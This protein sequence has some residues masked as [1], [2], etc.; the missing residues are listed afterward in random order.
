M[1]WEYEER[2]ARVGKLVEAI[3][4][5][6]GDP[7]GKSARTRTRTSASGLSPHGMCCLSTVRGLKEGASVITSKAANDN[8]LKTGQRR[9]RPGQ[10]S[11]TLSVAIKQA[12]FCS[13]SGTSQIDES[14][15]GLSVSVE[16]VLCFPTSCGNHQEEVAEG[17]HIDFHS[18]GT[19]HRRFLRFSFGFPAAQAVAFWFSNSADRT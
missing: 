8:H 13:R 16:S 9:R 15:P 6:P 3:G 12:S 10:G 18:W 5:R 17:I 19:F 11:S 7:T 14:P 4:L 2:V 1:A